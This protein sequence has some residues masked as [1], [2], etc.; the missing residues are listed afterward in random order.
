LDL[1]G[2]RIPDSDDQRWVS[3][4]V[5]DLYPAWQVDAHCRGTG[6]EN[7]FGES[8]SQ[9]RRASKLCDVCPVFYECLAHALTVREEYGVWAGTSGRVRRHIFKMMDNGLTTV[10]AVVE[11]FRNGQGDT[12]RLPQAEAAYPEYVPEPVPRAASGA[13]PGGPG[14]A[15]RRALAY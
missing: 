10:D 13:G 7:Y 11:R 9:V 14:A 2:Q 12:Y 1:T 3:Y 5:A 15:D 4:N 8:V 6:V